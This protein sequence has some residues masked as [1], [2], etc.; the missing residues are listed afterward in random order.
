[1][2]QWFSTCSRWNTS[3]LPEIFS[4]PQSVPQ[5]LDETFETIAARVPYAENFREV[6]E[7]SSQSTLGEDGVR[8]KVPEKI[9]QNYT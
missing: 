1:M 2:N 6:G 7:V 9:L 3:D 8:E 4:G 5:I